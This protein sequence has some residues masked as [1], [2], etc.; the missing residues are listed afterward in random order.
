VATSGAV[1]GERDRL[2]EALALADGEIEDALE[3]LPARRSLLVLTC[4]EPQ[5]PP[6]EPPPF[7]LPFAEAEKLVRLPQRR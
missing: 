1:E 5:L 6:I 4:R 2:L 7:V 3:R